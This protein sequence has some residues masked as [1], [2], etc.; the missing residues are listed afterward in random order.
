MQE[1]P[2]AASRH[3]I[4][5][6]PKAKIFKS[7]TSLLKSKCL[8]AFCFTAHSSPQA[9]PNLIKKQMTPRAGGTS[10]YSCFLVVGLDFVKKVL[11]KKL[12]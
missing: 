3:F 6:Q 7:E 9:F 5:Q 8:V 4:Y 12:P 11:L 10:I 1:M 2:P